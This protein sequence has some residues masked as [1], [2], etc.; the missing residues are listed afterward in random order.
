[1]KKIQKN[2]LGGLFS[3]K[4]SEE[5]LSNQVQNY[6]KLGATKSYRGIA[7]L[8]VIFFQFWTLLVGFSGIFSDIY[9]ISDV[10]Y[11]LIIYLP[12]AIFIYRGHRWAMIAIMILWTVEKGYL[13]VALGSGVQLVWW[14]LFMPYFF[15]A[16]KVESEHRRIQGSP[17][18]T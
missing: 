15:K 5:D 17:T 9:S 3:W 11:G 10:F 12:I 16:L 13:L 6:H 18:T 7:A 4:I 14:A 8:I 2:V 1:M